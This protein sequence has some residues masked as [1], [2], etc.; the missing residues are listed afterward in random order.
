MILVDDVDNSVG[1]IRA[2]SMAKIDKKKFQ[3]DGYLSGALDTDC[4]NVY[5]W[6][7]AGTVLLIDGLNFNLKSQYQGDQ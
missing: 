4:G 3:V 5:L 7:S 2:D 1:M 6:F